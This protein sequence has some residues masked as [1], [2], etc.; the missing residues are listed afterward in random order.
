MNS[1]IKAVIFDVG[2][3]LIRTHDWSRRRY[4]E[5]HLG[6][7]PG[8]TDAIVFHS[9]VGQKAQRGEL[10]DEDLWRWIGEEL[11]LGDKLEQFRSDFWAG[12]R[13]D[14]E[15]VEFI[16]NLRPAYQTAIISNATDALLTNVTS[17]YPMADAF[18]LIVGSAYERTMKPDAPIYQRTLERLGRKPEE[19]VFVDDAPANIAAAR[20]LGWNAILFARDVDVPRVLR[21]EFGVIG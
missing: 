11:R 17:V 7:P 21:E 12:D 9:E 3:V 16:R 6:L 8:G 10:T 18:D 15:L 2:G 13:L 20:E 5:T 19:V 14:E 4:W 1:E